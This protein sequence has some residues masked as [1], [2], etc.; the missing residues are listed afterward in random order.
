MRGTR[1]RIAS[2]HIFPVTGSGNTQRK[3]L[4]GVVGK[5]AQLLL[6]HLEPNGHRIRCFLHYT[7]DR[8]FTWHAH[9]PGYSFSIIPARGPDSTVA[10]DKAVTT[11]DRIADTGQR[12]VQVLIPRPHR[13]GDEIETQGIGSDKD[14]RF[15]PSHALQDRFGG[16]FRSGERYTIETGDNL[17]LITHRADTSSSAH[18]ICAN[19]TRMHACYAHR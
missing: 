7:G 12:S 13:A 11:A 9:L 3:K 4:P 1:E 15:V 10:L 16:A 6:G 14:S 5:Y 2:G 19:T 17:L 18:N 8:E